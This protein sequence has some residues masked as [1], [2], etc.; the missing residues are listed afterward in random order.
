MERFIRFFVERHLLV[1]VM[2]VGVVI[3]GAVLIVDVPREFIPTIDTPIINIRASLPGASARDIETK[4]TIPIEEAIDELDGV[5]KYHTIIADNISITTVELYDDFNSDQ[6]SIAERDIREAID[7]IT[8]FPPEMD[9]EPVIDQFDPGKRPILEVALSGPIDNLVIVARDLQQK[10]RT[11]EGV[12]RVTL[13]GLQDPE[14]RVL[15]DPVRAREHGVTLLEIINAIGRRNVSSTGGMLESASDRRQVIMWSRFDNPLQVGDT[16][17][18]AS[19]GTGTLRVSDVA[20]VELAREDT[21]LIT[22]TNGVPGIS[23]VVRKRENADMI[24]AVERIREIVAETQM[25]ASVSYVLV[26]DESF[27]TK[28][29]LEL[30]LN[31]GLLGMIL[32]SVVLFLF[33]RLQPA[34]W[35]LIGIPVVFMGSL[36]I[37]ANVGITLNVMA[38]TGFIIVLGMVVDDAVVVSERIVAL[39]VRGLSAV[40]AAVAGTVEMARPVTAAA[41]TTVLAFLPMT[42]VGGLPGKIVWQ[43]PAVVVMCLA[44]SLIESFCILPSHMSRVTTNAT[45]AKRDFVL[46]LE[47]SYRRALIWILKHRSLVVLVAMSLLVFIF[48]VIRPMIPF[49]LIPQDD[50]D[51]LFV[52]VTAPIG[53]PLEQTE[54]LVAN[55]EQ[56]I[57]AIS[58]EDLVAVTAR[59]GHQD[60]K[61]IDRERGEVESEAIITALFKNLDRK[62]TNSEW[63]QVLSRH[64]QL[65][66]DIHLVFQSEY[67]GPPTDEPVTIHIL[68]NDDSTRRATAAQVA[69]YLRSMPGVTEIEIDERPGTPQIDLAVNYEKLALRGLDATD[70]GTTLSAAFFGIEATEHRSLDD[71]TEL[72]VQFDPA[73]RGDLDAF[74]ET[75]VRS[76]TGE[77]VSLRDVVNPVEIPAV[78]RVFHRNGYRAATVRASFVPGSGL[79]A[80]S[81]AGQLEE[82]L[83]PRFSDIPELQIFN[84]GE[85]LQTQKTTADLGRAAVLVVLGITVVIW[86]LLGSLLETLFV[87]LV[88]PFAVAGVM[89][90]FFIH[91]M[92][93][94]MTALMGAIGLAGVVV[95]AS[96]VMVDAIHRRRRESHIETS[97]QSQEIIL[98]VVVERLRP[99]LVTTL[100]TLGGVLPT[101]YGIGGYDT[102]VSPM[103]L[104]I[105][106]GLVFSSLVTL[107]LVPVLYSM[108]N[109]PKL[110][111]FRLSSH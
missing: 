101:A 50:A 22:H 95:N 34:I 85:A 55:L 108:A 10:L 52:K 77:L 58:K 54:A 29:R 88:I 5:D 25:P 57:A 90:T 53:T 46:R 23:L 98:D 104:A 102:M 41:L 93:L 43:I 24:D 20:R 89:L 19:P 76:R 16:V 83:F 44:F 99:I 36:V 86:L 9:D 81:F 42:A 11:V 30:M 64:L 92:P 110:K 32:V 56:Q 79:S 27:F 1:N 3:L 45:V 78:N 18:K 6:I 33:M 73:V 100:T 71:T 69:N 17:L 62:Y 66:A 21:G 39:R 7:S 72:R 109:E 103:S 8:D 31:N 28:N 15:V 80:L 70:V 111:R 12:A 35:V 14:V 96:I 59:I 51:A 49:V 87:V 94:S 37:F 2:A 65:P 63:I 48:T 47:Q 75:R 38:L 107:F 74:L 67:M 91:N 26:N 60:T 40:E 84:G 61:G 4:I 13:V 82:E 68:N 105:G 97:A 106:W